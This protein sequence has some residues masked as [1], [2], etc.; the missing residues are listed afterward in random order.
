MAPTTV[1]QPSA[2][3]AAA[4]PQYMP[5]TAVL[6]EDTRSWGSPLP[7]GET[8]PVLVAGTLGVPDDAAAV[9]LNITAVY[10]A[11]YGFVTLYPCG[12]PRPTASTLNFYAGQTIANAAVAQPGE[13]RDVCLYTSA[14]SHLIV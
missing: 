3:A 4:A 2:A 5:M 8:L 7:A 6:A 13:L 9:T 10:P 14:A 11:G 12:Q 1:S